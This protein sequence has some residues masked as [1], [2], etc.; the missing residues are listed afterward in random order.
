MRS[1][2]SSSP[3]P[4]TEPSPR[5][6]VITLRQLEHAIANR[7]R[8]VQVQDS[9]WKIEPELGVGVGTIYEAKKRSASLL[10]GS[11]IRER[12]FLNTSTSPRSQRAGIRSGS[13]ESL[14]IK[15]PVGVFSVGA[16][17]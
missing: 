1:T 13:D 11:K 4:V 15:H 5:R 14:R 16:E 12:G 7:R 9:P 17:A 8:L 2:V 3:H 10:G 6:G